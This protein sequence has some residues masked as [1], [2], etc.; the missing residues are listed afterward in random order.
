MPPRS[1]HCLPVL[2]LLVLGGPAL[3]DPLPPHAAVRIGTVRLRHGDRVRALAFS[4]DGRT[5]ATGSD[6]HTLSLWDAD[7]GRELIRCRGHEDAVLALAFS[8]DGRTL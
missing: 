3:S 7:S 6:D 2:C 1:R 4:P 5:L 8:A